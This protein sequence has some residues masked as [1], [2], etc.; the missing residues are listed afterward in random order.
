[1]ASLAK[2]LQG[3]IVKIKDSKFKIRSVQRR[4]WQY[5]IFTDSFLLFLFQLF[6]LFFKIRNTRKSDMR[7]VI[8]KGEGESTWVAQFTPEKEATKAERQI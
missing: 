8:F 5:K 2:Y 4:E 6:Q 3:M 1:M 7:G